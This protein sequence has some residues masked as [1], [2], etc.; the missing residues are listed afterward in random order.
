MQSPT[1][2]GRFPP[3]L[4]R[5]VAPVHANLGVTRGA[6]LYVGALIGPGILLVPSLAAEAAG[7]ASVIAWA[8]LLA[9]SLPLAVTFATL[10]VR[11]PVD[12]GVAAYVREG[13]GETAA[14][15]T[16]ICF[17]STIVIGAPAV[18]L[19]GGFYVA[20]L[21][22]GGTPVAAGVALGMFAVVMAANAFGIR[23]SST[24]QLGL[25]AILVTV[26]VVAVAVALPGRATHHWTPFAPHGWAAVGTAANILVW[27]VI[28][29]EAMAQMAGEFRD[30]RRDLPRAVASAF[31]VICVL[32]AGLAVATITVTGSSGSKVPLADLLAAGFGEPGRKVTAVLAVALTMGTMNVYIGGAAKL[33]V[34]L[35]RGGA[36]PAWLGHSHRR[37]LLALSAMGV[38]V[39]ALLVAQL[40]HADDLVRATSASFIAVYLLALSAAVRILD[41]GVRALAAVALL[42]SVVLAIFSGPFLLYPAAA[43]ALTLALR[44]RRVAM[45][46]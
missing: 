3:Y 15:V 45:T 23:L 25:S 35:A 30:P 27:L 9:L 20:D 16:G 43:A 1:D 41:G 29:W 42:M 7:P 34:A 11:H 40:L 38:A 14:T 4:A 19:I 26:I 10:G 37:P 21:A 8:A 5:T 13:F 22:G 32:Y 2:S 31:A 24:L 6:A 44:G 17:L 28:G 46:A 36:L 18:S 12:G 39:L 33:G